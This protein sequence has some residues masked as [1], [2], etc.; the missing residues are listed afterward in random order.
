M[1][2]LL[3][4]IVILNLVVIFFFGLNGKIILF[5]LL[6][7]NFCKYF[8]NILFGI[9]FVVIIFVNLYFFIK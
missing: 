7:K 8:K 5:V 2:L 9:F 3:L 1:K 4:V 6:I